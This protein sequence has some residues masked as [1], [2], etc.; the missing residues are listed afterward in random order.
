MRVEIIMLHRVVIYY[1]S[2]C[3]GEIEV[4]SEEITA[5]SWQ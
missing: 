5:H 3:V 1:G 2:M 4:L